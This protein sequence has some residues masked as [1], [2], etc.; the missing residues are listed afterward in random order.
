MLGVVNYYRKFIPN[1]SSLSSTLSDLTKKGQPDKIVWTYDCQTALD[2]LLSALNA[3]PILILPD[4]VSKFTLRT[5]ASDTGLG[6]CLM[7]EREGLLHP[8]TFV[9]RKLLPR[10][11]RYSVIERECLAIVWA[12]QKLSRYLLGSRFIIESDHKPLS[13]LTSRRST[14]ARLSRWA[15]ALQSYSFEMS[16]IPGSAN[17][18]ADL[19]SRE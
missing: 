9:S 11:R 8:V 19:L 14:S 3:N 18:L 4:F 10:E 13:F 1:F 12:V 2:A 15:L 7:Q 16:H 6:A 17:C 5:D